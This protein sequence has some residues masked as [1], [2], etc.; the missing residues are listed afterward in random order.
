MMPKSFVFI[1]T[2]IMVVTGAVPS[3]SGQIFSPVLGQPRGNQGT[4]RDA[5]RDLYEAIRAVCPVQPS[6]IPA[7]TQTMDNA[8][9]R[10]WVSDRI[11]ALGRE[12]MPVILNGLENQSISPEIA[13]EMFRVLGPEAKDAVPFLTEEAQKGNMPAI[14]ALGAIGESARPAVPV[15]LSQLERWLAERGEIPPTPT[16]APATSSNP[17]PDET[18]PES[19]KRQMRMQAELGNKPLHV[20][21]PLVQTLGSVCANASPLDSDVQVV[22]TRLMELVEREPDESLMKSA[23]MS[24]LGRIG[25]A[26]K[27]AIPLLI[28]WIG[29]SDR[30]NADRGFSIGGMDSN[31]FP[32]DTLA[33]AAQ[34]TLVLMGESAVPAVLE[35]ARSEDMPKQTAALSVLFYMPGIDRKAVVAPLLRDDFRKYREGDA[36]IDKTAQFATALLE[37]DPNDDEAR[38]FL[39]SR[40]PDMKSRLTHRLA[41]QTIANVGIG[42]V[43]AEAA[44]AMHQLFETFKPT[45]HNYQFVRVFSILDRC[46]PE[47]AT[48]YR[49]QLKALTEVT[50]WG[51]AEFLLLEDPSMEAA[52]HYCERQLNSNTDSDASTAIYRLVRI[53]SKRELTAEQAAPYYRMFVDMLLSRPAPN[54]RE[55]RI[56]DAMRSLAVQG[57]GNLGKHAREIL[58][59]LREMLKDPD[60]QVRREA[61]KAIVKI[62]AG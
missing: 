2:I 44:A 21:L 20:N 57:L 25:P 59:M 49:E 1:L 16:P 23:A 47:R 29:A 62:Q 11:A 41:L 14:V 37:I 42:S 30:K 17:A 34:R 27:Q 18:I 12:A 55:G 19:L 10:A 50:G 40:I 4:Q 60:V 58:P 53:V 54:D 28:P 22:I 35:L 51:L 56:I 36:D 48:T 15:L 61:V 6:E 46:D 39:I 24:A 32:R 13:I 31:E 43:T 7:L 38:A 3:G 5:D 33:M 26:A 8:T 45:S 52:L 9:E